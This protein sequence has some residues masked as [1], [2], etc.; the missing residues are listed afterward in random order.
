MPQW[1]DD[2]MNVTNRSPRGTP[3]LD[4]LCTCSTTLDRDFRVRNIIIFKRKR[5]N[6]V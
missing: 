3:L 1:R 6:R 4:F 5:Q 2:R